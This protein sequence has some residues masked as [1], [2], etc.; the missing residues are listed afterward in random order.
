MSKTKEYFMAVECSCENSC[1][2][3]SKEIEKSLRANDPCPQCSD[4]NIKKFKSLSDQFSLCD[5]NP[6]FGKCSCGKRSLDSVMAHVLKV[7]L[8]LSIDIGKDTLRNG[9]IPLITPFY[10]SKNPPFIGK[11]SLVILDNR[12]K[13]EH[14]EYIVENI[15]EVKGV[16]KGSSNDTVGIKDS[17]STAISYELLSGCDIRCDILKSP[18]EPIAINKIQHLSYL[19]FQ[20]LWKIK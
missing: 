16:L 10:T 2:I 12:L 19:E 1:I 9:P 17:D 11:N 13:K 20:D 6:E 3:T 15:E 8:D 14:G 4:P 5:I 18:L 7:M